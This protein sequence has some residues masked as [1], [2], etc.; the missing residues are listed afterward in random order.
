MVFSG[1]VTAWRFAGWPTSR[2][3]SSVNATIEGVVRMPS[4]FSM[5]FGVFPSITA[6]HELV[7]PRSI[8]MT[9]PIVSFLSRC[10][11]SAQA[12][13]APGGACP[14]FRGP[15]RPPKIP[16]IAAPGGVSAHIGGPISPARQAV[17]E[18]RAAPFISTKRP[19]CIIAKPEMTQTMPPDG[20]R[21][22]PRY[23]DRSA[24]HALLAEVDAVLAGAPLYTPRMPKSGRPMSVRM[25]N[26][27]ALGWVTDAKGYRY[28]PLHP[29][30]G[31]PWPP[32]P[33]MLIEL[34]HALTKREEPPESCL[35]N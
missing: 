16:S 32:M 18:S 31:A 21:L 2:S 11:R 7:V 5:T 4:A 6:T 34:W 20:F 8:P 12:L 13:A 3:P 10:G 29:E 28:Q 27:G 9:L 25:T 30:T 35:I 26:C 33:R 17:T 1:L 15:C 23:L 22:L 24:Q 14:R 19:I